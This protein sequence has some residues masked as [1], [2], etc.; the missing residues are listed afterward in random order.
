LKDKSFDAKFRILK[1]SRVLPQVSIGFR[2]L[3]GTGLFSSEY[4]VAS[5]FLKQGLDFSVGIGWGKL[6]GNSIKN[7]LLEISNRFSERTS[8][9]SQGGEFNLDDYFSGSAGYFLGME[10][11]IPKFHGIRL[12]LEYDGTN[13]KTE[14]GIP[15]SQEN[16][17]NFGLVYPQTK[18][19]SYKLNFVRG[20]T[21]SFG[22][23]YQF[24]LGKKN[25]QLK[26]KKKQQKILNSKAIQI[27]TSKSESNLYK[28]GLKY[29]N[30]ENF[31]LQHANLQ[32]DELEIVLSQSQFRNPAISSGRVFNILNQIAPAS[33]KS[34]KISEINGGIGIYSA[35]IDRDTFKRAQKFFV[36]P[37]IERDLI[38]KPFLYDGEEKFKFNPR[39]KYPVFFH[40]IG[41][42][43]RS[44]IGGPDGFFFGDLK[45]K[46]SSEVLFSRNISL[47]SELSY[48]LYD[49]MDGLKLDSDSV[50]P[51]V[52]SDIVQYLR[53]SRNLSIQR[54]QLNKFGTDFAFYIL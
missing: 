8:S 14:N 41:P 16:N 17:Y 15:L 49:N 36:P 24:G 9:S 27:V 47:L 42:D 38:L 4:I 44:Q 53:K 29:L 34:F 32:N 20:N 50:L 12:K 7:P 37:D 10:Y 48:G 30:D 3:A 28:A 2:D 5:K 1:E 26:Y 45:I 13:Y 40:T 39:A 51:H 35:E 11:Y 21:L 46:S 33:I 54:M 31:Y 22:F 23:S 52:R 6:T 25:T 18:N 19:L 43:I